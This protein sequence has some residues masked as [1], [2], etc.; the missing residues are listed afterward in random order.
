M[1]AIVIVSDDLQIWYS[2]WGQIMA[3]ATLATVP[4]LIVFVVFQRWFIQ[5]VARTGI[6]G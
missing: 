4:V 5:S 2:G 6:S 3:Y 1:P